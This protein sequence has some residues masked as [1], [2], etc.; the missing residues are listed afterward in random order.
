MYPQSDG[1]LGTVDIDASKWFVDLWVRLSFAIFAIFDVKRELKL[2]EMAWD[3]VQTCLIF[4]LRWAG[5]P[6][7]IGRNAQWYTY[8]RWISMNFRSFTLF[9]SLKVL[10]N[11]QIRRWFNM[12]M[13]FLDISGA[14][15][16]EPPMSHVDFK[17][18]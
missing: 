18:W 16:G 7:K 12:A 6:I 10:Y 3:Q 4:P 13:S 11:K 14:L 9:S 8:F 5:F 17:K 1:S 2:L 15:D